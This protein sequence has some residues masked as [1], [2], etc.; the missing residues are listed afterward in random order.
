MGDFNCIKT[1]QDKIGGTTDPISLTNREFKE[2][3][4]KLN[5][6]DIN[7][8]GHPY[9]WSNDRKGL[10]HILE[11]LDR[12]IANTQWVTANPNYSIFHLPRIASDHYPILLKQHV[13]TQKMSKPFKYENTS[14]DHLQRW[15]RNTFGHDIK[16]AG[17]LRKRIAGIQEHP[18]YNK[19]NFPQ[20]LE[21]S[22][23]KEHNERLKQVGSLL[24]PKI[25]G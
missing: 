18:N 13:H 8:I 22:L 5:M 12:G 23:V 4:D 1:F 10:D 25:S 17:R 14:T 6:V 3:L 21:F 19:S 24:A 2:R 16:E 11:I 15:N 9:N 20:N 7:F